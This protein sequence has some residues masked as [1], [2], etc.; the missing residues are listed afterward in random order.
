MRLEEEAYMR[1]LEQR[2]ALEGLCEKIQKSIDSGK[3][4]DTFTL[5]EKKEIEDLCRENIFWLESNFGAESDA[6]SSKVKELTDKF[7]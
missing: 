2:E 4:K 7:H 6:I 5:N 3:L 1:S